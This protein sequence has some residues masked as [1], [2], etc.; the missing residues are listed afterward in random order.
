MMKLIIE[1]PT[2]RP[3]MLPPIVDYYQGLPGPVIAAMGVGATLT[4]VTIGIFFGNLGSH[5][6]KVPKPY[7]TKT[8]YLLGIYQVKFW[9][10]FVGL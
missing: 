9:V 2:Y 8:I 6:K 10:T 1:H 7:R 5:I 3:T 4:I